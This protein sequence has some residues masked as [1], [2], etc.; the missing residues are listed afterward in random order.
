[1]YIEKVYLRG[2]G[3]FNEMTK[4]Q[5]EP[6]LNIVIGP[7]ES[8]KT[9]LLMAILG[10]LYGLDDRSES[11]DKSRLNGW[12]DEEVYRA[13]L[14]YV[15]ND[16]RRY[17][18]RRDFMENEVIMEE[19]NQ[20]G[21]SI[22]IAAKQ[23]KIIA[24]LDEH[25]G[26]GQ[27]SLF[28][29]TV[30]VKAGELKALIDEKA[31]KAIRDRLENILTGTEKVPASK[32]IERLNKKLKE[33]AGIKKDMGAGGV[34]GDLINKGKEI[35]RQIE[36]FKENRDNYKQRLN[37][38]NEIQN[39]LK[40]KEQ[41]LK[42]TKQI[43]DDREVRGKKEKEISGLKKEE[44]ELADD[45][46][47]IKSA[48][49]ETATLEKKLTEM[50]G[51]SELPENTLEKVAILQ[52]TIKEKEEIIEDKKLAVKEEEK[53][54]S[55]PVFI[56][57]SPILAIFGLLGIFFGVGLAFFAIFFGLKASLVLA[58]GL[59]SLSFF[60]FLAGIISL[61]IY[62]IKTKQSQ[63]KPDTS[64]FE[65]LKEEI[66]KNQIELNK[67]ID[68]LS[69]LL[70]KAKVESLDD[71]QEQY[72]KFAEINKNL[73]ASKKALNAL[74]KGSKLEDLKAEK[75]DLITE[76]AKVKIELEEIPVNELSPE[77]AL[78]RKEKVSQ[79]EKE[80]ELLKKQQNT[81]EGRLQSH[82]ETVENTIDLE[83]EAEYLKNKLQDYYRM[84]DALT[85]ARDIM[86]EVTRDVQAI[87]VPDIVTNAGD[88]FSRIT[89]GRYVDLIMDEDLN[90]SLIRRT[91]QKKVDLADLSSGTADQ[92][93]FA[94]RLST[95]KMVC[96]DK[97]PPIILDDSFVYFDDKRL[98]RV[99][100]ILDEISL[101][102][103]IILLSHDQAFA[104]WGGN[105]TSLSIK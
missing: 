54:L 43:I 53:R 80:I 34:I 81:L 103:Q 37:E 12:E 40:D 49:K 75:E 22:E 77:E 18:I 97:N 105:V 73:H 7:N 45:I 91:G 93:Y 5:F 86:S 85:I 102:N 25:I 69:N 2:F 26:L 95:A 9:T 3:K 6:G 67:K 47:Q 98:E 90:I 100:D 29:N 23:K 44:R 70:V 83:E 50:K 19:I 30:F 41:E 74:L 48:Q 24:L 71:F 57:P 32:A 38:K 46:E 52:E 62:V 89:N 20:D 76:I 15:L 88:L 101:S 82:L 66:E 64:L 4:F 92:L 84:R 42:L 59:S 96:Q 35:G 51:F 14:T 10:V 13:S 58:I 56:R 31:L 60:S 36:T 11:K 87:A 68:S 21:Q 63:I 78:E 39:I 8:G 104:D 99:K 28:E 16:D 61:I 79:L 94:L 55:K 27:R 17:R 1:M 33:I 65:N 72:L